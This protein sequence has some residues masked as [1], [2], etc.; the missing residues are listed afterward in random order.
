MAELMQ[1]KLDFDVIAGNCLD[2]LPMQP[3]RSV[4]CCITSPPYWTIKQQYGKMFP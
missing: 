1:E 3:E 2:V 4:Q